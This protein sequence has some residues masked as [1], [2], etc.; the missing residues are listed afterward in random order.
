MLGS[1]NNVRMP[2]WM[3]VWLRNA[4]VWRKLSIPSLVGNFGDPF[5]YLLGIGYGLGAFIGD[6]GGLPYLAFFASGLVCSSA[7]NT[8]TFEGLYSAFTRMTLQRTWE[9]ILATPLRVQDILLGEAIWAGTKS[10]I[11]ASII[12]LVASLLG[13]VHGWAALAAIPFLFVTG[14]T[15]GAMALLVTAVSPSY[16]FFLYYFTLLVTPMFLFGGVF[17]PVESLPVA[18]QWVVAVLPLVHAVDIVR[19][20]LT[21]QPAEQL[22]LH[23]AVL[24]GYFGVALAL[25]IWQVRR[26]LLQ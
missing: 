14:L 23:L 20:L 4:L 3:A 15:F 10:L 19:P 5:L 17:F 2:G 26:R 13:A 8:A 25:A 12:V 6:I 24:L 9:G 7:M 16:D 21:G 22:G 1:T 18:V 11:S